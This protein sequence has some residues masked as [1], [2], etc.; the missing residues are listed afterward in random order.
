MNDRA[1]RH[2]RIRFRDSEIVDLAGLPSAGA[3]PLRAGRKWRRRR[4]V[5]VAGVASAVAAGLVLVLA[6]G[7]Y[8]VGVSGVGR[9]QLR[10]RAEEA[11]ERLAGR[12]M[13]A[14]IGGAR[15]SLSGSRILGLEVSDVSL[16]A[17]DVG[18]SVADV[19]TMQFG[20]R[21]LPLLRGEVE[22]GSITVANARF[23][24]SPLRSEEG[25]D[26]TLPFRDETGLFAP[27]KAPDVVF[28][29]LER[30][31][32][33][34]RANSDGTLA[35]SDI[36]IELPGKVSR[37]VLVRTA[38]ASLS[39]DVLSFSA[40]G[41]LD[42]R[43][44]AARGEA[45]A[46]AEGALQSF[47]ATL[48]SDALSSTSP[49]TLSVGSATLTLTGE[50]AAGTEL[51]ELRVRA[52][53]T[54]ASADLGHR[55]VLA[56][57]GSLDAS[58]M[59]GTDSLV[60]E[61]LTAQASGLAVDVHGSV[62][63]REGAYAFSVEAERIH[64]APEGSPEPPLAA[65]GVAEG[66][67]DPAANLVS[68]DRFVVRTPG[69]SVGGNAAVQFEPGLTPGVRVSITVPTMPV[70][71]A[72]HLWPFFAGRGARLWTLAHLHGGTLEDSR[73]SYFAEP[74]R[75][76]SG[77]PM[78]P[79]DLTGEF[80]VLGTGFD[81]VGDLPGVQ[82]A[83]G[84]LTLRGNDVDIALATGRATLPSGRT[85]DATNG[86]LELR[87]V[88]HPPL[89]GKLAISV[90]GDAAAGAEFASL[91]PLNALRRLDFVPDDFAGRI[92]ADV[93]ADIPLARD[94]P[95]DSLTWK[96]SAKLDDFALR[97]PLEGQTLTDADGTL[98]IDPEKAEIDL[99]GKLNGETATLDLTEPVRADGVER[100]RLVELALDAEGVRRFAPGL[101][102]LV[103]GP[104]K[105]EAD[106]SKPEQTL[107]IDLTRSR[108]NVPWLGWSKGAGIAAEAHFAM[109]KS[110][111]GTRIEKL[112][113][114]GESFTAQGSAT[115]DGGGLANARFTDLKLNRDDAVSVDVRRDGKLFRVA[116]QGDRFDARALLRTVTGGASADEG[117]RSREGP[118][119][120]VSAKLGQVVG[121]NGES[122][123]NAEVDY[124]SGG[125]LKLQAATSDGGAVSA[126][127]QRKNG[128]RD[129]TLSSGDA[130]SVLRFLDIYPNMRGGSI[131]VAL[132]SSGDGP[133]DGRINAR[134]FV[135]ADEPRLGR[136]VSTR[137]PGGSGRSLNEAVDN[138]IDTA[139]VRFERG[140]AVVSKG[141]GFLRIA[142]GVL[143]GQSIGSTFQGTL[144]DKDGNIDMTGTFMPAYGVNRIFG[145][146]PLFGAILG[147]GRDRGLIGVT[148]RLAGKARAPDLEVNPLSAI[149][150]G[151]FRRIF[152]Y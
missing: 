1:P 7:I 76:G 101:R 87:A 11:I 73:L 55:G 62:A 134:D 83:D 144:Y 72:K 78:R 2:E 54:E 32:V 132:A 53:V 131:E 61:K 125:T 148:F 135:I 89:I 111:E 64:S 115:L 122:W 26:W 126:S 146:I 142:D 94:I 92:E 60:V 119:V 36:S 25:R 118:G 65:T 113:I 93:A 136:L 21:L 14:A 77:L 152:E 95:R 30:A 18:A 96:V 127:D 51:P 91:Q 107:T 58:V 116:V 130:G 123:R 48:D 112:R 45:R 23:V 147:N 141:T 33:A 49:Q 117:G 15:V 124:R 63:A 140:S 39:G 40:E 97:K 13:A 75:L 22:L 106:V 129:L 151:I 10:A 150:P 59:S 143:R 19:G 50:R 28:A 99:A 105:V 4:L 56:G 8:L 85:L 24:A 43:P 5:T 6:L 29:A 31:F 9:E 88:N 52:D 102:G 27:G 46:G 100:R 114:E 86:R 44:F 137:P 104:V 37:T 17:G 38:Q 149:A 70:A 34:L 98:V 47:T 71:E 110:G 20:L 145:E 84:Y 128:R 138:R 67:Y 3:A 103:S 90:A 41:S 12:D 80:S 35:L 120:A 42:G 82:A 79:T 139:S 109:T 108:L 68:A 121:F 133:L 69:G 16:K 57:G 81:L 74:G 66:R